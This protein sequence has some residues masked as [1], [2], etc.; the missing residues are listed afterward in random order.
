MRQ[1]HPVATHVARHRHRV[2]YVDRIAVRRSRG[3]SVTLYRA[4]DYPVIVI[5]DAKKRD[6]IR[7]ERLTPHA[8]GQ[9]LEGNVHVIAPGATNGGEIVHVG[10]EVGYVL[11]GE[12]EL[13]V[14]RT[15]YRLKAGG[16][17]YFRSELPNSY[18]NA[19]E[20]VARVPWINSPSTF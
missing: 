15:T 3:A 8:E 1:D 5:E 9:L 7:L 17:F 6:A 19:G 11:E 14:G 13:T 2:Q 12:F 4:G 10:E 16:S 18:R 20:A